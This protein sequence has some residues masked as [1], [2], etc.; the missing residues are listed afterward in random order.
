M[1]LQDIK[2][3][4]QRALL[5][6]H[7][8]TASALSRCFDLLQLAETC[9]GINVPCL[10]HKPVEVMCMVRTDVSPAASSALLAA[11]LRSVLIC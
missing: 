5:C 9:D 2:T 10:G 11:N 4:K 1:S 3:S 6:F 7:A 8:Q